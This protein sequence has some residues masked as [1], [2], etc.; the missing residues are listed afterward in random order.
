[1][2]TSRF[3]RSFFR[4]LGAVSLFAAPAVA[5]EVWLERDGATVQVYVGDK[6]GEADTGEAI[7]KLV[8]TAELF[9][10]DRE[11]TATLTAKDD[12]LVGEVKTEGD[13]RFFTDRVW[14]PWEED[15]GYG[16][17]A[18][19]A[20]AGRSETEAVLDFELVPL[21]ADGDTFT[22]LFEGKPLPAAS[23]TVITPDDWEKTFKTDQAGKITLP[24]KGSGLYL[25]VA[26]HEASAAVEIGGKA[27]TKL[28]HVASVSFV[29]P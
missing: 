11:K 28:Y 29:V 6:T 14:A 16:A 19:H 25:L 18:F 24:A 15:N 23:V 2:K 8:A 21:E 10:R 3:L 7:A 22:L 27:V 12:H 20:K 5:H 26:H 1:M 17:G 9:G 4:A 13:V